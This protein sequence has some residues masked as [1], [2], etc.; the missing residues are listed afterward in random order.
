MYIHDMMGC[1]HYIIC[2]LYSII[3]TYITFPNPGGGSV[4]SQVCFALREVK[5][6]R[7]YSR[8]LSVKYRQA[9]KWYI[10]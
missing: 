6:V 2:S 10:I 8:K 5:C 4:F 1:I 3:I 9:D 7:A